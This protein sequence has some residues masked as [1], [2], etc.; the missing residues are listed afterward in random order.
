MLFYG[1]LKLC[2]ETFSTEADARMGV[3]NNMRNPAD[4]TEPSHNQWACGHHRW[5]IRK[6]EILDAIP[7]KGATEDY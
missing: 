6:F 1:N 7:I 5:Y 2:V 3:H 4:W